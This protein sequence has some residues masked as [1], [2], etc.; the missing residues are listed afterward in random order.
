MNYDPEPNVPRGENP[1]L[2][3]GHNRI[4]KSKGVIT[5]S[6]G[7]N[8]QRPFAGAARNAVFNTARRC[9]GQ[10]FY[11]LPPFLVAYWV[12]GWMDEK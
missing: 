8:A 6:L 5:Y 2:C 3:W 4:P 12:V 9:W 7:S 10:V 11:V 1:V